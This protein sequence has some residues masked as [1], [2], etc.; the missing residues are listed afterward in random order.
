MVCKLNEMQ[1]TNLL[2]ISTRFVLL[3]S[4]FTD[5]EQNQ[6]ITVRSKLRSKFQK[7]KTEEHWIGYARKRNYYVTL[8]RTKEE[9]V[10]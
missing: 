8:L 6:S 3:F 2:Y 1:M 10:L 9:V 5:K 7:L 4:Y